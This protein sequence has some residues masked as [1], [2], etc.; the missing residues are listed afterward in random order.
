MRAGIANR[1]PVGWTSCTLGDVRTDRGRRVTPAS[2]PDEPFELFSIPSFPSGRAELVRGRDIGSDKQSIEPGTVLVS[3]I[4]PRINRVWVAQPRTTHL[5]VASTEWIPFFPIDGVEPDYLAY[6]LRREDFR[7]YLATNV[8]GVG[9][10]L[11]RVRP[12]ILDRYPLQL[13]PL[14]EQRRIVA[15]L[16]EHLSELDAAV[17]GLERA[18]VRA[19]RFIE[20]VRASAVLGR[21][22]AGVHDVSFGNGELPKEWRWATLE[23]CAADEPNAITDGPFGSKLKTEHYT[24]AGPRVIRLQ[25]IGRGR[26]V[27]ARA[28]ISQAHYESLMKH[29]VFAGDLVIAALGESLPRCCIVPASLGPAIVKADCIRFRPRG[30]VLLPEFANIAL[31]SDPVIKR[32]ARMIHGVG[33]PRMNL[34]EIKS[35]EIPL[36]PPEVQKRL[37]DEVERRI[38]MAEHTIM[39]IDTQLARATRLRQS[40]LKHAFEGKLVPQDPNDEP[41]SVLLDRIRAERAGT[42]APERRTRAKSKTTPRSRRR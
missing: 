9:G 35:I 8:S 25:N 36:P 37:V 40:I 26:F 7:E 3:K 13:P 20:A 30:G 28:H 10:S 42:S 14:A 27:D 33:R 34:S 5:P 23:A 15:A 1:A 19:D 41:A 21:L 12:A 24:D 6:Y 22:F 2:A 38:G 31:N 17:A 18:R 11:M 16:E 29:R 32:A 4:N 39:D